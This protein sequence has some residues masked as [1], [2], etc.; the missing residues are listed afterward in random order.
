VL[1]SPPHPILRGDVDEAQR[2]YDELELDAL[3]TCA[4]SESVMEKCGWSGGG[5]DGV[6][7]QGKNSRTGS[8]GFPQLR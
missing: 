5:E 3:I 6:L 7:A 8:S 2:R 4:I 1:F